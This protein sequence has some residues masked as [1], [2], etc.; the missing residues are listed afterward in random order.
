MDFSILARLSIEQAQI[1]ESASS[2]WVSRRL[3]S[4][5]DMYQIDA[6]D[7]IVAI[8]DLGEARSTIGMGNKMPGIINILTKE[9]G[10]DVRE[11][12][13]KEIRGTLQ[14]TATK[15]L[16]DAD[17]AI[18][19]LPLSRTILAKYGRL[20]IAAESEPNVNI[21]EALIKEFVTDLLIELQEPIFLFVPR[22]R[23][24]YYEQ[25]EPPFGKIVEDN[26]PD[27]NRDIAA[28]GRCF[29]LDEWTASVFHCMRVLEHGLRFLAGKF[30][31]P[32][33][34]DSWHRVISGIEIGIPNL[35]SKGHLTEDDRR[36]ITAYSEVAS[37]FRYFKDAWRNNVSHA[38]T[39][40]DE[41]EAE[42][43]FLHVRDFMQE[44][45]ELQ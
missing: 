34:V 2:R 25:R 23:R 43:I 13:E 41:R 19:S 27:A 40:Y 17:K 12:L 21:L 35:R 29:A 11:T 38:K 45:A 24:S 10:M 22:E 32:F 44:M 18:K 36:S 14:E 6:V 37:H 33:T 39:H 9:V 1:C 3:W 30:N 28:A 16:I 7:L 8:H 42:K 4:L 26:F 5:L 31:V 15:S 20:R